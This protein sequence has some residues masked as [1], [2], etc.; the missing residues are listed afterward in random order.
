MHA[1][2]GACLEHRKPFRKCD[3][4]EE[5]ENVTTKDGGRG[6]TYRYF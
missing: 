1:A 6:R 3:G 2:E 5:W 4:E